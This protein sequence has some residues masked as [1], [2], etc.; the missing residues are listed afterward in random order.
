[1]NKLIGERQEELIWEKICMNGLIWDEICMNKLIWDEICMNKLIWERQEE[2]IW[3]KIC[4]NGLIW[5]QRE[6]LYD[7]N[8]TTSIGRPRYQPDYKIPIYQTP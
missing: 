3:E 4:M 5:H 7:S 1:M 2:L 8:E 6:S